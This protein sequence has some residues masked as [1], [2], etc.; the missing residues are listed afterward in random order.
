MKLWERIKK[1]SEIYFGS[2]KDSVFVESENVFGT[3]NSNN[4]FNTIIIDSKS[5]EDIDFVLNNFKNQYA[6][7]LVSKNSKEI[8]IKKQ[9]QYNLKFNKEALIISGNEVEIEKEN[10]NLKI[11]IAKTKKHL[12]DLNFLLTQK[13]IENGIENYEVVSENFF[14]NQKTKNFIGYQNDK[15][16]C[17]LST[18]IYDDIATILN[19]TTLQNST[20]NGFMKYITNSVLKNKKVF[21]FKAYYAICIDDASYHVGNK[22]LGGKTIGSCFVWTKEAQDG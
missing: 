14:Y 10:L 9:N 3:I 20:G 22:F 11:E 17:S 2:F 5:E 4:I 12:K 13:Y 7:L 15:P 6:T 18:L 21:N 16:V 8:I 19:V 1:D